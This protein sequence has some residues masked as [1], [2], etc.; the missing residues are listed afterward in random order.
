MGI[1][2]NYAEKT[3]Q[4]R[5]QTVLQNPPVT[6]RTAEELP[7]IDGNNVIGSLTGILGPSPEE[8]AAE[9][10]RLQ[11][12]RRQMHGW[13][14]LFNGMRHLGN[15]YYATKGA[16]GQKFGDPHQQVE[17]QYQDERRRLAEISDRNQKYYANLYNFRR[18]LSDDARRDILAK[19]QADYY[20]TRDEVARMKAENDRQKSE[21]ERLKREAEIR[22]IDARTNYTNE[23]TETERGVNREVKR[24]QAQ[25][26]R[27]SGQAAI[28][29]A[30]KSGGG[31]TKSKKT[32]TGYQK[33]G[34]GGNSG[35]GKA[36]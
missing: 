7:K 28:T 16:P 12:H 6:A 32:I 24:A 2:T 19:A 29:R 18:Q 9:E 25:H 8:R 3:R 1:F 22:S 21:I 33:S 17:Q 31:S 23:R 10:E 34:N 5:K 20:G 13:T 15:L 27:Q 35:K 30:N 4:A 26:H 14:A 36:Y 11:N